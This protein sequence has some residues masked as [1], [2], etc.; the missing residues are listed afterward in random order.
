M[1]KFAYISAM[2]MEPHIWNDLLLIKFCEVHSM[3]S[4]YQNM[5]SK[6]AATGAPLPKAKI[7]KSQIHF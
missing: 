5:Y 4:T 3:A 1:D 7:A 2:N 6:M